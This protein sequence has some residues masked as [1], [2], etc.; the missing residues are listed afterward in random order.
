MIL[1]KDDGSGS[2]SI[3]HILNNGHIHLCIGF[4]YIIFWNIWSQPT[5]NIEL[6][7]SD[8]MADLSYNINYNKGNALMVS[9]I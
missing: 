3:H 4:T 9:V 5:N 7:C 2:Y 1:L 8:E 6:M